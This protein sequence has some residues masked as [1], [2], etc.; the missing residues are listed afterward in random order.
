MNTNIQEIVEQIHQQLES[1][2]ATMLNSS[3][4]A[5]SAHEMERTLFARLREL[6]KSLYSVYILTQDRKL[7]DVKSTVFNGKTLP[8]QDRFHRSLRTIFGL[9]EFE[10]GYY[11]EAGAGKGFF[12]LDATLN[13]PKKR[14]SD[15]LREWPQLLSCHDAY[16][17]SGTIVGDI[18]G[19][20]PSTRTI[21]ED[22]L[23]DSK[24]VGPFYEAAPAPAPS[25][26]ASVL[27]AQA[28]GKGVPIL[29]SAATSKGKETKANAGTPNVRKGKGEKDG[30][31]KEA[32]ATAV[33]TIDPC[34]RTP[35]EVTSSLF[36]DPSEDKP[37]KR[38]KRSGPRNKM[39]SATL[40]GKATA[41]DIMANRA[42]E[43]DG[44]HIT[45]RVALTDGAE[46]LQKQMLRAL[47]TFILILDI[48]HAVEYLWKAANALFGEKSPKRETW[49]RERVLQMLS[50]EV[51]KIIA[52]F[53]QIAEQPRCKK[54]AKA[55]LLGVAAYF[56]RNSEYM[57]YDRYLKAGWP[58][59][60][61]VIE[62]ACRHLI[63]DR[64]ELA[65][66]RWTVAGAEALLQLRSVEDN[67]DWDEF[68]EYRRAQRL[69]ICYGQ[70]AAE[71]KT[72]E[73]AALET[74]TSA[75]ER[76]AA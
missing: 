50:G 52:E 38:D 25:E 8:L 71:T 18:I 54:A 32:I 49:V 30:C 39:L 72:L 47:P 27:V 74:R 70:P 7:M 57:R 24:L 55:R 51:S 64:C 35:E 62:G 12:L 59:A 36:K 31:K 16:H 13:L 29:K 42:R 68:H 34:V 28:D 67:G 66:M 11:Y 69:V 20:K 46:A 63:K 43:R 5:P 61:G 65:G 23:E 37:V 76:R 73:K 17:K 21:E 56:E 40:E 75:T 26:E 1:L 6:G 60:T 14:N 4:S 48:I 10:R 41:I 53:R 44:A 2:L 33:Y 3:D 58:I 22:I 9:I 19:F 45:A 15:L